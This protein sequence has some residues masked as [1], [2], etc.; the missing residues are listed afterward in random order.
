MLVVEFKNMKI[1]NIDFVVKYTPTVR[2]FSM[3]NR[4]NHIVGI[5]LT[6][7]AIHYM[8]DRQVMLNGGTVYFFYQKDDYDVEVINAGVAYSVHFTTYGPIETESFFV[9]GA[10]GGEIVRLVKKMEKEAF[11]GENELNLTAEFYNLCALVN[12]I[13]EKRYF[14]R[15]ARINEAERYICANFRDGGCVRAA[16]EKSGLSRRRFDELFK[17]SFNVTPGR[18]L[19]NLKIDYAKRLLTTSNIGVSQVAELCG[20]SDIYYFSKLFKKETGFSPNRYRKKYGTG[21]K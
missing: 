1:K 13:Y 10:N 21:L 19:I 2:E 3:H 11:F 17:N 4:I 12:R 7:E 9:H 20:T 8:K 18:Y 14:S 6:G 5:Q 15:D 16:A